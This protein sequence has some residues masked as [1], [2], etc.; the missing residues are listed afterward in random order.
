MDRRVGP[1]ALLTDVDEL[2]LLLQLDRVARGLEDVY[3]RR[4]GVTPIG[5][6]V[7]AIALFRQ[8]ATYEAYL[9]RTGGLRAETGHVAGGVVAL[10]REGRLP[11]D[12]RA[13]LV[14]ELVHLLDRRALGPALPP[15][16]DEGLADDLG[17]SRVDADGNVV[18][19]SLSESTLHAG[20]FYEVH[21]GQAAQRLLRH[22]LASG[23]Y[24]PIDRLLALD[25]VQFHALAPRALAYSEASFLVRFL[26]A[27]EHAP[28]FRAFLAALAAGGDPTAP[29]LETA[30]GVP[31]STIDEQMRAWLQ[32]SS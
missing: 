8:K 32:P 9:E 5:E 19:G 30:L 6:P 15:W 12:V 10:Y 11:E 24:V 26:L 7:E 13:T 29:A 18:P 27:G 31:L 25:D 16:I 20:I 14:H 28:R 1:Y 4:Y 23:E 21:G 17:Q 3:R 2:A 22:A